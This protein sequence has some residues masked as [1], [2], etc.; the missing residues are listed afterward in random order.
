MFAIVMVSV[1]LVYLLLRDAP[2]DKDGQPQHEQ[3]GLTWAKPFG[4]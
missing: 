2:E 1:P 4:R 3:S